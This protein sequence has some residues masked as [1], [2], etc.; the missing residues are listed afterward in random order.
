MAAASHCVQ[1]SSACRVDISELCCKWENSE[2]K[3]KVEEWIFCG[4]PVCLSSNLGSFPVWHKCKYRRI[5]FEWWQWW[6]WW[7]G[8]SQEKLWQ[9]STT[10]ARER[11]WLCGF[12]E[13]LSLNRTGILS[14]K[15][16]SSDLLSKAIIKYNYQRKNFGQIRF[17]CRRRGLWAE[18]VLWRKRFELRT[19]AEMTE[20]N[21]HCSHTLTVE[22]CPA[23][24]QRIRLAMRFQTMTLQFDSS[25][26]INEIRKRSG[27]TFIAFLRAHCQSSNLLHKRTNRKKSQRMQKI[28]F[29]LE[30]WIFASIA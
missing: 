24:R 23:S 1:F 17:W 22:M 4:K 3:V 7:R 30:N 25:Q 5:R 6:W 19:V 13:E 20:T 26:R 9:H 29:G 8:W 16:H 12:V 15:I 10:Y 27:N 28:R 18:V 11:G 14:H 2:C 21:G